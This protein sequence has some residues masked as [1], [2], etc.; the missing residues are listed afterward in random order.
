MF[1][2]NHLSHRSVATV[3]Q[4]GCLENLHFLLQPANRQQHIHPDPLVDFEGNA[5]LAALKA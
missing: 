2:V 4:R 3:E 5:Q 1:L